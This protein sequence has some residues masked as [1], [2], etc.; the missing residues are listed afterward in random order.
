[1]PPPSSVPTHHCGAS[2]ILASS[3]NPSQHLEHQRH[4][5]WAG[6]S[7]P[8]ARTPS[9]GRAPRARRPAARNPA[10]VSC[11]GLSGSSAAASTPS[12]TTSA[13]APWS[14][15]VQ[16]RCDRAPASHSSSPVPGGRG[17]FSVRPDA[18]ALADLVGVPDEVRIPAGRGVDVHAGV[19]HVGAMPEDLLRAVALVG[20]DVDRSPP[21][22]RR[23]S[24]S[25]L[26]GGSGVVEVARATEVRRAGVVPGRAHRRVRRGLSASHQIGRVRPT[27]CTARTG[28]VER[29]RAD[30]RHGVGCVQADLGADRRRAAGRVV[31]GRRTRAGRRC[32]A[33][34]AA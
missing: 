4:Q 9:A 30:Q 7:R 25:A 33:R 6:R 23:R 15:T 12:E 11:S 13:V 28:S 32:T 19:Q 3:S 22:V 26:R 10:A 8:P 16:Q 20:V 34:P 5:A 18:V 31:R 14:R 21:A 1:M 2:A 17:T 24:H 29:A 27:Q